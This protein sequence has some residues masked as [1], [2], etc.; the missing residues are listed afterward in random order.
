MFHKETIGSNPCLANIL[1][2]TFAWNFLLIEVTAEGQHIA[3]FPA[4]YVHGTWVSLPHFDH[5]GLWVDEEAI[6]LL[7]IPLPG[8]DEEAAAFLHRQMMRCIVAFLNRTPLPQGQDHQLKLELSP[9][10]IQQA[11]PWPKG[12]VRLQYRSP[13]RESET[14]I[15]GKVMSFLPLPRK[16]TLNP[17]YFRQ[18]IA[19][20]IR[21]AMRHGLKTETG[22]VELLDDFYRV[23]RQNIKE[24]GSFG[25]PKKFFNNLVNGYTEGDCL[26][27]LVRHEG[28]PVGAGVLLTW[29]GAAENAW[30]A[31]LG[32]Y[33]H[34]YASYLL[35]YALMR[36]AAR[37]GC[38][39]YSMGRSTT[40]SGV[41][42]YKQQWGTTDQPLFMNATYR[43]KNPAGLYPKLKGLVKLIPLPLARMAD[44]WLAERV[45]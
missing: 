28:K 14:A 43:Q 18:E 12:S 24:L 5:G 16:E 40:G 6:R 39:T 1:K 36:E 20:K 23:Y 2:K 21:R 11:A 30:F 26:L 37:R 3:R 15:G 8:N 33:N 9:T 17:A 32:R 22:G 25:L 31:T 41:H 29:G 35:H 38:H 10:E 19:R 44:E 27:V 34:M 7:D 4:M 45:Y 42:R 13:F